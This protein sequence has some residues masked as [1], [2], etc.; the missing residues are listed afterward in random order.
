MVTCPNCTGEGA[1]EGPRWVP[2]INWSTKECPTCRGSGEVARKYS[3]WKICPN[4][5]GWGAEA[6]LITSFRCSLCN[7]VGMVL[8]SRAF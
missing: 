6:P 5:E 2:P 3:Q 1:I 4:C 7:G 8:P